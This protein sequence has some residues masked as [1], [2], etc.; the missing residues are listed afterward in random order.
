MHKDAT[1]TIALPGQTVAIAKTL[2][3]YEKKPLRVNWENEYLR[4]TGED[5]ALNAQARSIIYGMRHTV[6]GTQRQQWN[7]GAHRESVENLIDMLLNKPHMWLCENP[8]AVAHSISLAA[9]LA[10]A[11]PH[12][13]TNICGNPKWTRVLQR[14]GMNTRLGSTQTKNFGHYIHFAGN[15]LL[16]GKSVVRIEIHFF[17]SK[18][19]QGSYS[20]HDADM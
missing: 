4:T 7:I 15:V 9:H 14:P 19:F 12:L 17:K 5:A 10:A 20:S 1:V 11:A 2:R 3:P 13:I 8:R 18:C 6:A 16:W